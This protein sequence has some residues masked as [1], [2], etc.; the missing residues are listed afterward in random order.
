M[1]THPQSPDTCD[2]QGRDERFDAAVRALHR[3]A[4]EHVSPQV[5]WRL[6]PAAPPPQAGVGGMF[7]HWRRGPLLAGLGAAALALALG[8]AIRPSGE[9]PMPAADRAI[10]GNAQPAEIG[11]EAA[12][13][14]EQDP[15]FYAWLASDDAALMAME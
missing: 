14:L 5:R 8:V 11:P 4:L 3:A 9:A 12:F 7:G 10:A 6:K 1:N 13:T 15:D 2:A